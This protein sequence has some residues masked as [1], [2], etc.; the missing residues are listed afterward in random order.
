[1]LYLSPGDRES[2]E[3]RADQ[4]RGK[5]VAEPP[6]SEIVAVLAMMFRE[7]LGQIS[8]R[9]VRSTWT[10]EMEAAAMPTRPVPAPSSRTREWGVAATSPFGGVTV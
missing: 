1:M 7:R 9:S 10:A 3:G 2:A 6:F 8:G 4:S 5:K